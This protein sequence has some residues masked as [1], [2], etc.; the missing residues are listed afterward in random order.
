MKKIIRVFL[1]GIFLL[2]TG[3]GTFS[4][5]SNSKMT[6]SVFLK[7][8]KPEKSIYLVKTNTA[9]VNDNI[10]ALTKENLSKKGYTFVDDPQKA[11]YI[12]RINTI[13][14][15]NHKQQNIAK[16]AAVAGTS[17]GIIGYA[18]TNSG[19]AG[20]EGALVGAVVGGLFAY[21]TADG[22][23]RMQVDVVITE[24]MDGKEYAH[25]TRVIAEAKQV[26]LTPEE[27]QPILEKQVAKSISGIFL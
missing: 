18:A 21:A 12:L 14:I 22:E 25:K 11:T 23:V 2:L 15:N 13:N 3:C 1:L 16:G 10:G 17:A 27:G 20:I 7:D 8:L 24:A 19:T 9:Q 5:E 26:H 6:K 4:L